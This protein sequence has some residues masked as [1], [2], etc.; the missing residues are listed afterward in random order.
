MDKAVL[1]RVEEY[2]NTVFAILNN[3]DV[4]VSDEKKFK[5]VLKYGS[6]QKGRNDE[7]NTDN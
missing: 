1:S 4:K 5:N 6:I 7:K 2:M 3:S